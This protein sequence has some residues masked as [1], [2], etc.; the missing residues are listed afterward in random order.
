MSLF[1]IKINNYVK[2]KGVEYN[3]ISPGEFLKDE[4]GYL[5]D[6]LSP[7]LQKNGKISFSIFKESI[8]FN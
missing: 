8:Q 4:K 3:V 5:L 7:K 2:Y 1:K 6:Q